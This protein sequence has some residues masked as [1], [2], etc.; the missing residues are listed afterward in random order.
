MPPA[1]SFCSSQII[2]IDPKKASADLPFSSL[3]TSS[4]EASVSAPPSPAPNFVPMK[5][6]LQALISR[7]PSPM[8]QESASDPAVD[9]SSFE[10]SISAPP[11][12]AP[13][14]KKKLLARLSRS[15]SPM[16]Q[17][18]AATSVSGS[19]VD[20]SLLAPPY[21]SSSGRRSPVFGSKFN[22]PASQKPLP[23][24]PGNDGQDGK[25]RLEHITES[26]AFRSMKTLL[27]LVTAASGAE[28]TGALKIASGSL[29]ILMEQ[30]EKTVQTNTDRKAFMNSLQSAVDD[31]ER[32]S[33]DVTSG[34]LGDHMKTLQEDEL[35]KPWWKRFLA[36]SEEAE[37]MKGLQQVVRDLYQVFMMELA[38]QMAIN[39]EK[40]IETN[41]EIK[42]HLEENL[43]DLK[44]CFKEVNQLTGRLAPSEKAEYNAMTSAPREPCTKGTRKEIL[45]KLMDWAERDTDHPIFW[46]NGMAGTGK[47]TIAYSFC[48]EL[49]GKQMLGASFFSSRS[50][51][52]TAD[53]GRVLPTIAYQLA[54]HSPEFT[55]ALL[56]SL[57]TEEDSGGTP[58]ESQFQKLILRPA[59][60]SRSAFG[61]MRL[62]VVCDGLDE[63]KDLNQISRILSL[64]IQHTLDLPIKFYISS[65]PEAEIAI[66]FTDA[67]SKHHEK[68]LLHDVAKHFLERDLRIFLVDRFEKIRTEKE[69]PAG[70][71]SGD[72]LNR[73]LDLSGKLFIYAATACSFIGN[74]RFLA[75][76]TR[77]A[78]KDI[79]SYSA[80]HPNANNEASYKELDT[81]YSAV[82]VSACGDNWN[83]MENEILKNILRLL[84]AAHTPLSQTAI[85]QLLK[86]KPLSSRLQSALSSLQSVISVP[87][88]SLQPIQIFHA[89]FPD[90][91]SDHDRSKEYHLTPQESHCFLAKKCLDY[92]DHL[93]KNCCHLQSKNVHVS[94]ADT[95]AYISKPLQYACTYW[96]A[97]YLAAADKSSLQEPVKKFFKEHALCWIECMSLL[98]KLEVAVKMLRTL[99]NAQSVDHETQDLARDTRRCL[100]QCLDAV[101]D[102]PLEIYYSA[103]FW[104]PKESLIRKFYG[105]KM[106][107]GG[108]KEL[109]GGKGG[110]ELPIGQQNVWERCEQ[111][112]TANSHVNSIALSPNGQRVVS[113]SQDGTVHIWNVETGEEEQKLKGHS[114]QVTSVAFSPDGWQVVSGSFD[115]TVRIWNVETGEEEWKKHSSWVDSH[116]VSGCHDR[117]VYIWNVKT[118]EEGQKLKGHSSEVNSV[119]FSPDGRR[120]VSGSND[121]TVRIWNVE[122]GEEEWK[123]KHS[124]WANSVVFSP[125]G[126]HVVS[127]CHDG[128][129]Y[130]WNVK[131]GEEEQKLEGHSHE[132][133]SVVFSPDGQRAVSGSRDRTVR[134]WNVKTGKEEQ[135]LEGHSGW[136]TSVVFSPDGQRAVSGSYDKTVHIWNVETAEER[137]KLKGHS[138]W[139]TSVAFSQDGKQA[140]SGSYDKTVCIWNV[141]TG[142]EEWKLKGHSDKVTSVMFSPDGWQV[143][144]GSHD[145]T[146]RIWNVKTGEEEQ[147][148]KGHSEQVTSVAFSPDRKQVV[149]GSVDRTVRIWNV[150]T[151][152]EEQKLK[153]HSKWVNSVAFSPDGQRVVSG[154]FDS[155]VRIWNVGTGEEE[156]KKGQ[157]DWVISVAFSPGGW[158]V[159]SGC[160]DRTVHIWNV[161]TGEEEQKLEG[162]SGPVSSVVF[163]PDG[164]QV[165]SG[166]YD[167]T[168][169]I[170]NV[171]T[172]Q[173]EQKLK[174]H[175][176]QVTPVAFSSEGRQA[177]SGSDDGT[178]PSHFV[179]GQWICH[180]RMGESLRIFLPFPN[181]SCTTVHLDSGSLCFGFG[182]GKVL[183]LKPL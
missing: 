54:R 167:G 1:N 71:P 40:G 87:N 137:Q 13:N 174:G 122:T 126:Q 44:T 30:A 67:N 118:G 133:T 60:T 5:L 31:L 142:E 84:I 57:K 73:L 143:V 93:S 95:V 120:A 176:D 42:D 24:L 147:K 164:W 145:S 33:Q 156:W 161:K 82:L 179:G 21:T 138:D 136:V 158:Q 52:E 181:F 101:R 102:H 104:L 105:S 112:F 103:L 127:G 77:E 99:G 121:K 39:I 41:R 129:V 27:K 36:A 49:L 132:V 56:E 37:A 135:K 109:G 115:G 160:Q 51:D 89:S 88:H 74:P 171:K 96:I 119:A 124:S 183:V 110:W 149:S 16:P 48:Q 139:V 63:S 151:G 155:T 7:S 58:C 157:S 55:A 128:T 131:T 175:S 94:Q 117:T 144:S 86:I 76:Q 69:I 59:R 72:Q 108:G 62:V 113:G 90:F 159:V 15:P 18:P 66:R 38:I 162:H 10:A 173:E 23:D 165:V 116:V 65:R 166:S 100:L 3:S 12:P 169:C 177:A 153:R 81:L 107:W 11:S 141:N 68:F 64:L 43:G 91:M 78:L 123:K 92:L 17:A 106:C 20:N 34:S 22:D 98:G 9:R 53:P 47:T 8:P 83:G 61:Q 46:M 146:V 168:V 130:I 85:A 111:I 19:A 50:E 172:G 35:E 140:V 79:L 114:N 97:H 75:P 180:P 178:V 6:K 125:D 150:K 163:S 80:S 4:F 2:A 45:E 14:S 134:I 170:W 148:L 29:L 25:S 152:K 28:P 154:S 70:W 182:S 26:T 32:Y